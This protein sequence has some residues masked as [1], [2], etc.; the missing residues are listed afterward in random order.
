MNENKSQ[1]ENEVIES[2]QLEQDD[3]KEKLDQDPGPIDK[4]EDNVMGHKKSMNIYN[5]DHSEEEEEDDENYYLGNQYIENY[6]SYD[7]DDEN[8][9][10]KRS[11]V[12]KNESNQNN[13]NEE[14]EEDEIDEDPEITQIRTEKQLYLKSEIL[15][16][17]YLPQNFETFLKSHKENGENIGKCS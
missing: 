13:L 16:K 4:Q 6:D 17:Q 2:S 15:N 11:N 8:Y 5:D 12:F 14:N 3:D 9:S 1:N 7:E 10:K